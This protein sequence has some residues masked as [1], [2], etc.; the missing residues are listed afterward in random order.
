[1][2]KNNLGREILLEYTKTST[3]TKNCFQTCEADHYTISNDRKEQRDEN[4]T[5]QTKENNYAEA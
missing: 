4:K 3:I 2:H 1:M 5:L